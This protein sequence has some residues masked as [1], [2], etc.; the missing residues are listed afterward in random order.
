MHY[1]RT[2]SG[3]ATGVSQERSRQEG[4]TK[5]LESAR[6]I[7]GTSH[8]GPDKKCPHADYLD[9]VIVFLDGGTIRSTAD[10]GRSKAATSSAGEVAYV[11]HSVDPHTEE[12]V[13]VPPRAGDRRI[14]I[15]SLLARAPPDRDPASCQQRLAHQLSVTSEERL[16]VQTNRLRAIT[17][18]KWHP[19]Q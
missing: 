8:G 7:A 16:K 3:R 6:A 15:V 14:E 1:G 19:T 9:S 17:L 10:L 5:L 4:A 11:P 18:P 13:R 12:A 2:G